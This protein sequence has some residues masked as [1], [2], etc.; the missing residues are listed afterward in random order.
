MAKIAPTTTRAQRRFQMRPP[1]QPQMKEG[2]WHATI[3]YIPDIIPSPDGVQKPK[4]EFHILGPG[5]QNA[6]LLM[7]IRFDFE[8][9]FR[10]GKDG[11][12]HYTELTQFFMQLGL[13]KEEDF[14]PENYDATMSDFNPEMAIGL[15]VKGVP[16]RNSVNGGNTFDALPWRTVV[17]A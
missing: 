15:A 11:E 10:V 2:W 13:V 4:M 3:S 14:D 5:D 9:G 12:R 16:E 6:A 7:K 1:N 17:A 8:F